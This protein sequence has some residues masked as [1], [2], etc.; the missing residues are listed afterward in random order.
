[1]KAE[2]L[3][4][5]SELLL[6]R[7]ADT[8]AQY[9]AQQLAL[10]GIEL[11]RVTQVG[12]DQPRVVEALRLAWER[13]QLILV[14]GGLG[15]T[16]DDLTRE[17]IAEALG[18]EMKLDPMLEQELKQFM[19]SR[20]RPLGSHGLKQACLIPSAQPLPNPYGSAPGWWVERQGRILVA[21]PGVPSE[22]R[23]MWEDQV[24]PRLR[25]RLPGGVILSR[26]L[27]TRGMGEAG[28]EDCLVPL[29]TSANP[30]LATYASPDGVQVCITARASDEAQARHLIAELETKARSL[31]V[32]YVYAADTETL[33]G[34]V[35][36]LLVNRGLT[37][38]TMESC[39]GGLLASLITDTPG[40]SGYFRG[41]LVAYQNGVKVAWGLDPTLLQRYGAVSIET[42]EA[43][44]TLARQRLQA[45][46][47]LSI[48]GVAGPEPLEGKPVGTVFFVLDFRGDKGGFQRFYGAG[49]LELKRR[50]ALDALY[51]LWL[52]LSG[53]T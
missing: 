50:A 16:Q 34:V 17:S 46:I 24:L 33:E 19:A 5:G 49:R 10:L 42:A 20:G 41:G 37:L 7:I 21:M 18:E 40:S 43:M 15:P 4:V 28:I 32:S 22:M 36:R 26:V 27:K 1:M 44:A 3:S 6:G 47:G 23:S 9:L 38:A 52:R 11:E 30:T 35:G 8:N 13:S 48:T 29:L 12:D 31:L 53:Q 14:G 45:D 39:T 51:Q 25:T 2:I